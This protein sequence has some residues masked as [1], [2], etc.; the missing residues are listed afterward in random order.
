[1]VIYVIILLKNILPIWNTEK[2]GLNVKELVN[3]YTKIYDLILSSRHTN[4][5]FMEYDCYILYLDLCRG[6]YKTL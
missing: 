4:K 1:M 3:S 5:T 6:V 2:R